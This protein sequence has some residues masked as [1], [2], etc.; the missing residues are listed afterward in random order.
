MKKRY[1]PIALLS[2]IT[3]L[4]GCNKKA[5]AVHAFS[6]S[7]NKQIYFAE[8]NLQYHC[9]NNTWRFA[10][11][12]YDFIG[13]DN[14]NIDD[15]YDGYIDLFSWGSTGYK[16]QPDNYEVENPECGNGSVDVE[17]TN[18]DFGYYLSSQ[19]GDTYRMF[20]HHEIH[21]LLMYRKNAEKLFGYGTINKIKGFF[22]LPDD[23]QNPEG[24]TFSP[25]MD[26]Q[27]KNNYN[28][29]YSNGLEVNYNYN[30]FSLDDWSKL[31]AAGAVFLPAGGFRYGDETTHCGVSGHYWTNS[32]YGEE[33]ANCLCCFEH[34]LFLEGNFDRSYGL[35][36]RLIKD[37]K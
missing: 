17:N 15:N 9:K 12:A 20:T 7:E 8:S 14:E 2:T 3:M 37:A 13:V 22:I 4:G 29:Y 33:F 30:I 18:W 6:V 5:N 28:W 19:L 25:S 21:Y 10:P 34:D 36:V 31:K 11:N 26:H 35:A 24:I 23:Y 27:F 32:H 1:L 16:I